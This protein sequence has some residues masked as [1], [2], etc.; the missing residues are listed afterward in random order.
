MSSSIW[1]VDVNKCRDGCAYWHKELKIC[2][3]ILATGQKRPHDGM[4]CYGYLD[5]KKRRRKKTEPVK[6]A[7]SAYDAYR[8]YLHHMA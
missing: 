3:Y 8:I 4:E 6:P 1:S 5:T 2:T 7:I